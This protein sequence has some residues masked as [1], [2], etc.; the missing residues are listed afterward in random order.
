MPRQP[1]LLLLTPKQM[2]IAGFELDLAG[3]GNCKSAPGAVISKLAAV[4][5]F[6]K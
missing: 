5:Y 4:C 1:P 2:G 6:T 3:W